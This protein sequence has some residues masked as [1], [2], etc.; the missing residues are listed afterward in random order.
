M[1]EPI[2]PTIHPKYYT[3]NP[4]KEDVVFN[5]VGMMNGMIVMLESPDDRQHLGTSAQE[6]GQAA[7]KN[8]WC[9]VTELQIDQHW[10]EF[11]GIYADGVKRKRRHKTSVPWLVKLSKLRPV[12]GTLDEVNLRIEVEQLVRKAMSAQDSYTYHGESEKGSAQAPE[13]TRQI[14]QAVRDHMK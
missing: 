12:P 1:Q 3:M 7:I 8:A 10:V 2:D 4:L 6:Q 14:M 11:I 5:S 13:W 9:L